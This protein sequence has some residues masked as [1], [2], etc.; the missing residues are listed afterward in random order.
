MDK[1]TQTEALL[2]R[3]FEGQTSRAEEQEL[4]RVFSQETLPER[5]KRYKPLFDWFEGGLA[6][7][8]RSTET[9][10]LP[11]LRRRRRQRLWQAVAVAALLTGMAFGL[12]LLKGTFS[13]PYEGS[14]LV[15]GGVKITDLKL[16]R[17]ELEA[18]YHRVMQQQ[19]AYD[20]LCRQLD[21]WPVDEQ[22]Y[23]SAEQVIERQYSHILRQIRDK[24][25]REEVIKILG[26]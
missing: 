3:F 1:Y 19:D 13:D 15:R 7:E 24:T 17:P 12:S 8:C 2:A 9:A 16:I 25:A 18:T 11:V 20:R 21:E 23:L 6:D 26:I 22:A 14:Y 5:L 10:P 4:Y